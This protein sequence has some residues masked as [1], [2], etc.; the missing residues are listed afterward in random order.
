MFAMVASNHTCGTAAARHFVAH[1]VATMCAATLV[2]CVLVTVRALVGMIGRR[3][4]AITSLVQFVLAD[5]V[6]GG[7]RTR[8]PLEHHGA[9]DRERRA[10]GVMIRTRSRARSYILPSTVDGKDA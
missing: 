8:R 7:R 4:E 5:D 2:F 1:M 9:V 10:V 3:R 6:S